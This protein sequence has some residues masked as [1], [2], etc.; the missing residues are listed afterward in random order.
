MN[1]KE[2][3]TLFPGYVDGELKK[4]IQASLKEHLISCPSCHAEF[5]VFRMN[6]KILR[7]LKTL[8]PPRDYSSAVGRARDPKRP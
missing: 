7:K 6:L 8:D 2:A 5:K 1:C 4:Q 3:R